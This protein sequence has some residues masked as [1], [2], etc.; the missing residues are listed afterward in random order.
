MVAVTAHQRP[1]PKLAA[2]VANC[3]MVAAAPWRVERVRAVKIAVAEAPMCAVSTRARRRP[4]PYRV[5]SAALFRTTAT[6]CS[7]AALASDLRS[8]GSGVGQIF[9]RY[10]HRNRECAR[11]SACG[12]RTPSAVSSAGASSK[13]AIRYAVTASSGTAS[14]SAASP[15]TAAV[16]DLSRS[17]TQTPQLRFYTIV[18][19]RSAQGRIA[20]PA[21]IQSAVGPTSSHRSSRTVAVTT[22]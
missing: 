17:R 1:A 6:T 2:T 20:R 4:V 18:D 8:A 3:Q 14:N 15:A 16:S 13:V 10:R 7:T 9:V 12:N 11:T 22:T 21:N 5:S 19:G